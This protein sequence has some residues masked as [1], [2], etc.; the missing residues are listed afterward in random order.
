[1]NG[2]HQRLVMP[3]FG[4]LGQGVGSLQEKILPMYS[5]PNIHTSL[6]AREEKLRIIQ[7]NAETVMLLRRSGMVSKFLLPGFPC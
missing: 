6:Q 2:V 4:A 3:L 7:Y 1:M 5:T